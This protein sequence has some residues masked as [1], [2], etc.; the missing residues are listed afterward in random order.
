MKS[1]MTVKGTARKK[2]ST[3][4]SILPLG[5]LWENFSVV[6]TFLQVVDDK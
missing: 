5:N 3:L 4:W 2:G 1:R 6:E